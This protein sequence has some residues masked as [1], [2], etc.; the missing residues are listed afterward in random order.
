MATKV[1]I[2]NLD[3]L[4]GTG[5]V[6]PNS[7]FQGFYGRDHS[8]SS[9]NS[10]IMKG[11]AYYGPLCDYFGKSASRSQ[12]AERQRH[13]KKRAL[14]ASLLETHTTERVCIREGEWKPKRVWESRVKLRSPQTWN[15]VARRV[16]NTNRIIFLSCNPP[17]V[18]VGTQREKLATHREWGLQKRD[19]TRQ[20]L[21]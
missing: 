20:L 6:F 2:Y 3:S 18:L 8:V 12:P 13:Q 5:L 11:A 10:F 15:A 14:F 16:L 19:N 4:S 21:L 1:R 9:Q 17:A 7:Q